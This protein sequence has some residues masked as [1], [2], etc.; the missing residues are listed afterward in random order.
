M[1]WFDT[2]QKKTQNIL[3]TIGKGKAS[4]S[5]V[6]EL[7]QLLEKQPQMVP[8][9]A[10]YL[11]AVLK[12]NNKKSYMLAISALNKVS[13]ND[14]KLIEDTGDVILGSMQKA[15]KELGVDGMLNALEILFRIAKYDPEKM[16]NAFVEL[17]ICL[18]NMN[19]RVRESSYHLLSM[20]AIAKPELYRGHSQE[21]RRSL[22]GL[23]LDERIY[24]CKIISALADHDTSIVED[25]YEKLKDIALTH[26]N[27]D[28]RS[29]A[30]YAMKKFNIKEE[31]DTG[32]SKES[33][34]FDFGQELLRPDDHKLAPDFGVIADE[35]STRIS[36]INLKSDAANLLDSMGLGHLK[37]PGEN[38]PTFDAAKLQSSLRQLMRSGNVERAAILNTYGEVIASAGEAIEKSM[39]ANLVAVLPAG[40]G[41]RTRISL[42]VKDRNCVAV[43]VN[44]KAILAVMTKSDAS[45]DIV[46]LEMNKSIESLDKLLT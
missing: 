30:A 26:V 17:F 14:D 20:I 46:Q 6:H 29:E 28:L 42:A 22:N 9:V 11:I 4:E 36:D 1:L 45:L 5:H 32:R 27:S 24:S 12:D 44:R 21:L 3:K 16:K 41:P 40:S 2:P 23:N 13:E 7:L 35:L 39:L 43:R 34:D 15:Q 25:T 31:T 10:A 38:E 8:D 33:Q 37:N 19:P 18:G